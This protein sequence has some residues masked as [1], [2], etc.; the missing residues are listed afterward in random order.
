VAEV[1][2]LSV[3]D[4]KERLHAARL[5][6]SSKA[7]LTI[8]TFVFEPAERKVHLRFA[9]GSGPATDGEL[10]TLDLNKLWGK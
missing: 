4:L 8:Q 3:K 7:D 2:K 6:D 10:T 9:D 5:R 1:E